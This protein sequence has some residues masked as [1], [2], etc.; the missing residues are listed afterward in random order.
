LNCD[1]SLHGA[2]GLIEFVGAFLD[3][4]AFTIPQYLCR[5]ALFRLQDYFEPVNLV[6]GHGAL[7]GS[8]CITVRRLAALGYATSWTDHSAN[9]SI[10]ERG[11]PSIESE[12]QSFFEW[13]TY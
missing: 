3:N 2:F 13:L 8:V 5:I 12:E 1:I 11:E 4:D 7:P 10:L 6:L 9:V